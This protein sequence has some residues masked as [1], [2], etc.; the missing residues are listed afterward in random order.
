MVGMAHPS[1]GDEIC[2]FLEIDCPPLGEVAMYQNL[3]TL[4]RLGGLAHSAR[5]AAFPPLVLRCSSGLSPPFG[6]FP[7]SGIVAETKAAGGVAA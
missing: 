2:R 7:L 3:M 4:A 6:A 5:L 1:P